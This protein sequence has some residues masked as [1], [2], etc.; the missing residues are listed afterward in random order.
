MALITPGRGIRAP[1]HC[2]VT[3]VLVLLFTEDGGY[4]SLSSHTSGTSC[5]TKKL[6]CVLLLFCSPCV[7]H[8]R[9]EI[10]QVLIAVTK[11][12]FSLCKKSC[13][14]VHWFLTVFPLF[15]Q[16]LDGIFSSVSC[17][18]PL[19]CR[20]DQVF[21]HYQQ[22]KIKY[23]TINHRIMLLVFPVLSSKEKQ[24]QTLDFSSLEHPAGGAK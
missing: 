3:D 16:G 15:L 6:N 13:E 14:L 2:W 22:G 11:Y 24:N 8:R 17:R 1:E 23:R 9:N 10:C 20:R 21:I 12:K 18:V 7:L 4:A 5:Y 19:L